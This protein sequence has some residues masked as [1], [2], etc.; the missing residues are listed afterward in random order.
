MALLYQQPVGVRMWAQH[1]GVASHIAVN[2]DLEIVS[3]LRCNFS[4]NFEPL[5]GCKN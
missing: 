1:L 4:K 5:A 2:S 3:W